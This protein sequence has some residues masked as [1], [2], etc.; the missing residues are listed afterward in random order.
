MRLKERF[1]TSFGVTLWRD[2]L[3]V[4]LHSND[5]V[6]YGEVAADRFPG[7]SYETHETALLV[8]KRFLIPRISKRKFN[9]PHVFRESLEIIRGHAMAKC[10][11]EYAFWDL[12]A[13][14]IGKPLFGL[15]GGT[16]TRVPVGVSIGI[17]EK[18]S[19]LI[20]LI[21]KYLDE[22]YRRIKLKIAPGYDIDILE[23][24]REAFP[25]IV[26]QV[27]ANASYDLSKHRETILSLD[28]YNLLMIE[29]PLHYHD[30]VD[31]AK[32]RSQLK[33]P[34]CLDESIESIHSAKAA[35]MLGSCD[36]V[37]LKPPRVGG[38]LESIKIYNLCTENGVGM[39]IGG[40]LETGIGKAHLLHIASL[41]NITYPSDISASDRYW[42]EDVID[43][44][45]KLNPVDSTID[46]P[47]K[48]GIGVDVNL[49]SLLRH[50]VR[51]WEF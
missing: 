10:A 46:V 29:Q 48:P 32:L 38:I 18:V 33:T 26:L 21:Q 22:G 6:G 44:P 34:I 5:F 27:D 51:C 50:Q 30:L 42:L 20:E 14:I 1:K 41:S 25:E 24:V 28:R 37:N 4:E 7:F 9:S 16:R 11:L 3:V 8:L 43:P 23:A 31:H 40:M 12:Y 36:I 47:R 39:W 49:D 45:H 35:V 15:Y 13:K 19:Y 17:V 2:I